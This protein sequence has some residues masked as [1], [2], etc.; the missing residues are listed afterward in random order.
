MT[1][2]NNKKY[3]TNKNKNFKDDEMSFELKKFL[4]IL[5]SIIGILAVFWFIIELKN[6]TFTKSSDTTAETPTQVQYAE[7]LGGQVFNR[8][9]NS[10]YVI[11]A[12]SDSEFYNIYSNYT[13]SSDK[14]VYLVDLKN[15]L[16]EKYVSNDETNANASSSNELKVKNH[17]MIKIEDG[18]NVEYIEGYENILNKL[19]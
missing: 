10:Y 2:K 9:D 13:S 1:K 14:K 15:P 16:N 4:I 12:S 18:K 17:T 8:K 6:G 19:K 3:Y 5:A 11:F 7:I